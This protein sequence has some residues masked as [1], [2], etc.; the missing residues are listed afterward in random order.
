MAEGGEENIKVVVRVRDLIEREKGQPKVR[1][2]KGF[3]RNYFN[4]FIQAF[5]VMDATDIVQKSSQ[6][7]WTFDRVYNAVEENR[8]VT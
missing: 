4:V 6:K 8:R 1:A 5:G 7:T 3:C 2:G